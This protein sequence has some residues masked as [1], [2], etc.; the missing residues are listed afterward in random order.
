M[1][2]HV[3]LH[4][5]YFHFHVLHCCLLLKNCINLTYMY[6][7]YVLVHTLC[8]CTC[9]YLFSFCSSEWI[10]WSECLPAVTISLSALTQS[11]LTDPIIWRGS[12]YIKERRREANPQTI[13]VSD[14]KLSLGDSITSI[15]ED[16]CINATHHPS[17]L[18]VVQ[19]IDRDASL[20]MWLTDVQLQLYPHTI[21]CNV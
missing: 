17:H 18:E 4:K 2:I 11:A 3:S 6:F 15:D 19:F 7:Y 5:Q 13:E 20:L 14:V 10:E 12:L 21:A 8:T 1:H 9:I 16:V